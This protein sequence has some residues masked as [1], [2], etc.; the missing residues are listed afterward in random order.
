[1]PRERSWI[2]HTVVNIDACRGSAGKGTRGAGGGFE[3]VDG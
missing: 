1:M 2:G 3:C